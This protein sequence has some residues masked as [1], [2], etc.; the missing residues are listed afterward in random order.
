MARTSEQTRF[1]P[2]C[3]TWRLVGLLLAA[4]V[5][6]P[7][8]APAQSPPATPSSVTI[9]RANGTLTATWPAVSGA[10]KYHVTYTSD[11][12]QS[13]TTAADP[14]DN[15]S[16]NSIT[17]NNVDNAKT[18][19]VGVRA[20]NDDDQW[21][22]W[23][24]SEPAGPFQPP[25]GMPSSVTIT[26]ANGTLTATWPAVTGATRYHV[27]YTSDNAQGWTVAAD[28]ADNHSANSITI[29]NVDNAKTY[30]VGVRAGNDDDQWSGWRNSEPA[31]PFQPP[32]G[33][34]A[35]VTITR[36]SGTLTAT[37]PAVTGATRYH[38][39]YTSDDTKGW[40][41]VADPAD[42][43][44]ANSITINNVDNAKT[45]IVGVRAGNDG[46]W[47]GW[48]N[49][50]A[51]GPYVP[52]PA[53]LSVTPGDGYLD[54]AWD[55][56][57]DATGYDVRAKTASSTSWHDVA[58]NV[59]ATSHRYT[60]T[61]MMDYVAVRA[62][63]A[64]GTSAWTELSR[65][66]AHSWLTTVQQSG[67]ASAQSA[68]MAAA[69][70]QSQLTAPT[71]STVLRV[72]GRKRALILN[73]TS[74]TGA[75]GYYVVCSD[76][77][78]WSWW[79]CG[80]ITSQ[81]T[82]TLTVSSSKVAPDLARGRSYKVAVRAVNSNPSQAS[83]WTN[84]ENIR[85]V[86]G[87]LRDLTY[88][89]ADGQITLRWTP[90]FWTTGY[91]IDCAVY[92]SGQVA[93]YTRCATLTGQDDTD[94][95]HSVT[96]PHSTNS[97]YTVDNTKTYDI[98]ITS[99]NQWDTGGNAQM[100]VPLIDPM[101]L[102]VSNVTWHTARLTLSNYAGN[103]H[104][105]A[106]TGPD[107]TC[108]GPVSASVKAVTGLQ[109]GTAYTYAAYSASGCAAGTLLHTTAGVSASNLEAT[110]TTHCS[111][112]RVASSTS[113]CAT[114]FTTGPA[115]KAPN[116]YTLHSAT[117]RLDDATGTPASDFSVALHALE[118]QTP[119]SASLATLSGSTSPTTAGTYT[120]TCSGD[121]C[122][123]QPGATYFI[124]AT[125]TGSTGAD[126]HYNW[127]TTTATTETLVPTGNG[128]LIANGHRR[129]GLTWQQIAG[130]G[131]MKVAAGI[132]ATLNVTNVSGTG[133]SL[134]VADYYDA[135][136]YERSAPAGDA[137]CHSVPAGTYAA[138]LSGLIEFT[139]YTYKAYDKSGCNSADELATVTFTTVADGL[140]SGSITR[141]AAT[142][143]LAGHTGNWWLK[144]LV[145]AGDDTCTSKGT[146]ATESLTNLAEDKTY[147]YAAYSNSACTTEIA[148][149]TFTT[150]GL[151]FSSIDTT[152]ATLNLS[153]HT[154]NW[155]YQANKA[156]HNA[157]TGPV[158]GKTRRVT[159]LTVDTGYVYKAYGDSTCTAAKL[160]AA[161]GFR[162]A[163]TVS[164]LTKTSSGHS[165]VGYGSNRVAGGFT[166]GRNP[167][168]YTLSYVAVYI[169]QVAMSPKDLA[170]SVH[171]PD[172][173]GALLPNP[174]ARLATLS[175]TSPTSAGTFTYAC[176]ANCGLARGARYFVRLAADG[177]PAGSG[178]G[179]SYTDSFAEDLLPAD[180]GWSLANTYRLFDDSTSTWSSAPGSTRFK[181]A[182]TL[183]PHLSAT[184]IGATAATLNVNDYTG[185]AWWHKRTLPSGDDTCRSV[186]EGTTAVSLTSLTEYTPYTW[187]AYDK[188]GCDR[189]DEIGSVRFTATDDNLEAGK[190][191]DT[192]AT[193]TLSG[194]AGNWWLKRTTPADIT[195][196][197]KGTTKTEDLT[198][199][200]SGVEYTY[201]A[202]DKSGCADTDAIASATFATFSPAVTV[203]NLGE[204]ASGNHF[205][206]G[207][208]AFHKQMRHAMSFETGAKP[209]GYTLKSVTVRLGAPSG[210]APP[211]LYAR[212]FTIT[213]Q[214][215]DLVKSLGSVSASGAGNVT[216]TCAGSGCD[217]DGN[218]TYYLVLDTGSFTSATT[219]TFK[220]AFTASDDETNT[221][222]TAGWEIGDSAVRRYGTGSWLTAGTGA[223]QFS[224]TA[225]VNAALTVFELKATTATL[226]VVDHPGHAW[227][228]KR[229][230]GT[231]ADATCHSVAAGTFKASLSGLSEYVTYTY[232]AYDKANCNSADEIASF[233]FS[234]PGDALAVSNLLGDSATLTLSGHTGAWWLKR[235]TPADATC[236]S[237]GTTAAESL[238]GLHPGAT[239]VYKAYSDSACTTEIAR[240]TFTTP[241]L[242][243]SIVASNTAT[244]TL[245]GY[246]GNW[247][248]KANKSPDGNCKGPVATATQDVTGLSPNTGY[249]YKAY[250]GS[251]CTD[252]QRIATAPFRTTLTVS[253]LAKAQEGT[254]TVGNN[255]NKL[256]GQF[257]TGSHAADYTLESAT[258]AI[259][260]ING[261]PGPLTVSIYSTASNDEPGSLVTTLSGSDP[262]G[263][264][265][266][267]FTCA[268]NC[269]LAKDTPYYVHLA[270]DSATSNNYYE[271]SYTASYDQDL[272]PA[273]NGWALAN[274]Y[275]LFISNKWN[276]YKSSV[277][278]FRVSAF[279]NPTL[280]ASGVTENA[281][282]LAIGSHTGGAWWYKRTA[283][284][285]DDT[286]HAV[287]EGTTTAGLSGLT[288][289]AAHTYKAY[290]RPGCADADEI[291]A[292]TFIATDDALT[293]SKLTKTTA[294]LTLTGHTGGWW[295]KRTAG[296]PADATCHSVA[297][298]T[299]PADLTGLTA[300]TTYT[301]KAYD[302]AN[303]QSADEIASETFA[304]LSRVTVSNLTETAG[305]V[306]NVGDTGFAGTYKRATGFE[307]GD[308]ERGYTLE[309]VTVSLG[310]TRGSPTGLTARIHNA[311]TDNSDL[312]GTVFKN[313]GS[314]SPAGAGNATW[315]CSDAGSG[316]DLKKETPYHL[317]LE[318]ATTGERQYYRWNSTSSDNETNTPTGAG[319]EISNGSSRT[320]SDGD[321]WVGGGSSSG[322][323]SITASAIGDPFISAT[324]VTES[325]ATLG[326]VN[327]RGVW[328]YKRTAGAPADTTCYRVANETT[329]AT[330]SGLTRGETYTYTAY[331][332]TGC[333]D[334]DKITS[335]TFTIEGE[336]VSN[337]GE[338]LLSNSCVAGR[339]N[340][341]HTE[342]AQSFTTGS[343]K[344]GYTLQQANV[345]IRSIINSPGD[346]RVTLHAD[347]S[348]SPASA[349][350]ATLSGANPTTKNATYGFTCL[351]C[352]LSASTTYWL[353]VAAPNATQ[354][355]QSY[356]LPLTASDA[357]RQAPAGNG[358][359]IGNA[360]KYRVTAGT[361][362]NCPSGWCDH[363]SGHVSVFSV[364]ATR[365]PTFTASVSTTYDVSD[366]SATPSATLTLGGRTGNW[367]LK[368]TAPSTGT[369]TAGE[370]DFSHA[371]GSL[372]AGTRYTYKAYSAATCADASELAVETFRTE[373]A[374]NNLA[375]TS[376]QSHPVGRSGGTDRQAAQSFTAGPNSGGYTLT[377]VTV[378]AEA[379][380]GT[381]ANFVV[382]L[383]GAPSGNTPGSVLATLSGSN[384]NGGGTHAYTCSGAGCSLT[385][386]ATYV[387]VM[388]APGS[389]GQ[390][391]RYR[392]V[393]T[394]SDAQTLAPSGNGW[395]IGDGSFLRTGSTWG[396][397]ADALKVAVAA[398]PKPALAGDTT[399]AVF[400]TPAAAGRK[401]PSND[402]E[403][404]AAPAAGP[405][406][407]GTGTARG[408]APVAGNRSPGAAAPPGPE[409]AGD[410]AGRQDAA[411]GAPGYVTNL[412]SA[413]SGD[414]DV[415]ATQRQAV[416]FTTGPS[417]GGYT[418][419][420]FTAALRK[421]SGD[422]DLVLTLHEMASDAYGESSQP[423]ATVL[424][425]LAGSAP[426]S[427]AYAD[428]TSTCSGEG[429]ILAPDTTYFVVAESSGAGAY[430][431]AY[432]ASA[433]LYTETTLPTDSG[434]TLGASHY[435]PDDEAWASFG[436]WHHARV[437]FETHPVLSVGNLAEAPHQDA[438]FPSGDTRCAVGFTTGDA[439]GGYTLRALTARFEDAD[440]P[441]GNLGGLVVTLHEDNAGLPGPAL[442]T[443]SGDNPTEAGDY[444]YTCSGTGCVLKPDTAYFVQITAAA[445]AYL[446]EAYAWSATLSDH[447]T[448]VPSGNGWT[449]ANGTTVYRSTW[450]V[451]PDVGLLEIVATP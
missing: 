317:V 422:A 274:E 385:A 417:P 214:S 42:N 314:Q 304:T 86:F 228:Y 419:K 133:S 269:A 299:T 240:E 398:T 409:T 369:C 431:W 6:L 50:A 366:G 94:A 207:W 98:R 89:R 158:S 211:D 194:Y 26:R 341:V 248:Y 247:Y 12:A 145:P 355:Y 73:W 116:G 47:S 127:R 172:N 334:A 352:Y 289:H 315:T 415:D 77:D 318:A 202:Y 390:D 76:T 4:L 429:C 444:T 110:G 206:V 146:A 421:V 156:P 130:P 135:W 368:R 309:S 310:I 7:S 308:S 74:V 222:A 137:T 403:N 331:D 275:R 253:N 113:A 234:T 69:Q 302:R 432:V 282:T 11:N 378:Y 27:T 411:L 266:Y 52:P 267:T 420:S 437:D 107:S 285:G 17:I 332:K 380:V 236:K 216:W 445:G 170:V 226:N 70:S 167:G 193:L 114:G 53:N 416:A 260:G 197:S 112:G 63:N 283:P 450:Q 343:A 252:A 210:T 377:T 13:W 297:R 319:W 97:A 169:G 199:L 148:R 347:G 164:N 49:S 82:T 21:S 217:L 56:V 62:R 192:T 224:I 201:T 117:L 91:Q 142:L 90:N 425:T 336:S 394:A 102:T 2:S 152:A 129:D 80:S 182:A 288:G 23:R 325:G 33:K 382:T 184:G 276:R 38:V 160:L 339:L 357:E 213:T 379:K 186:A 448:A 154:G 121:G 168:G 389:T 348:G 392:I 303:C 326:V 212:I 373:V 321:S 281:A 66:P 189:A 244:L 293:A 374:V 278:R 322:Q 173:P 227:W 55:A 22:G 64:G 43:H 383:N 203:S 367:W 312:P 305:S 14:A 31:G 237:K 286:C 48:T 68:A 404:E 372:N 140:T 163:V 337:L 215:V 249:V 58:S 161:G 251:A 200:T 165:T 376:T 435:A 381:P 427:G 10:T 32:P 241:A 424:A 109:P 122:A 220:W 65:L 61:E 15:H 188:P 18:Y 209:G 245:T 141:N 39:T 231:P 323:F 44:S 354:Q 1:H 263:A 177:S 257:T 292:V 356:T 75:T 320:V 399:L 155:Y 306:V 272:A 223:G 438:C 291:A 159:A 428:V 443:L 345:R 180:N 408:A 426:A 284:S 219:R 273:G 446:S 353:V 79:Q 179:W 92:E 414:S 103:W 37:W 149:E 93:T 316:C 410:A 259:H 128:W 243:A 447:E 301:Y 365:T 328:W 221:P 361:N 96:I 106:N 45:Y 358:W 153:G 311:S 279:A 118:G 71:W 95:Q 330:L 307:T 229:S 205:Q 136:W 191:T 254:I 338:T 441:D 144:R 346:I 34:P 81:S 359:S 24:N 28:P 174:G 242:A 423:S 25:P 183:N 360:G 54:I 208:H 171:S 233:T 150:D 436:D 407:A 166:T 449:L 104:Y 105:K 175:G 35:S 349:V 271:A 225:D 230:A 351:A 396:A 262:T 162:T 370:A 250:T 8:V 3:L 125:S 239:Y 67:G 59:T 36:A 393:K 451:Y 255:G 204:T 384:P 99:T 20:G 277:V 238:S 256:A 9:T 185:A 295:Y 100:F 313:L 363:A 101:T 362:A 401:S 329:T 387:I 124:V 178:Y 350:L 30:I 138:T 176:T 108:K 386:G 294:T 111:V 402:A 88:T 232:K 196:K 126:N 123:L 57:S 87:W 19:I 261:S 433:N 143:T 235:T 195:C 265:N 40:T 439:A 46:G 333:Q 375:E 335:D 51:A 342:C 139:A 440:D 258:V 280:A 29:N 131:R 400:G 371:L 391:N 397:N 190:I 296:T 60:T 246:T 157:C 120:Y 72:N 324:N 187:K 405:P 300:G 5:C 340:N 430:A 83:N 218:T 364:E 151:T 395:L 78:G 413:Q 287:A 268:A 327:Y 434:W 388:S 198:T 264:G 115:A 41:V 85:P 298:G 270:A 16:A 147:V 418:L 344:S 119:A 132:D 84:S 406:S 442:A 290:D 134:N 181:V 412:A